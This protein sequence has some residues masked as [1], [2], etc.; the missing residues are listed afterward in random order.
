MSRPH[1]LDCGPCSQSSAL[2]Q[3]ERMPW[4]P[5]RD[6]EIPAPDQKAPQKHRAGRESRPRDLSP[7][8]TVLAGH[9]APWD[10]FSLVT[11]AP[12]G[13]GV[14]PESGIG[15]PDSPEKVPI[16]VKVRTE[17]PST[18]HHMENGNI[19]TLHSWAGL[20]T[21]PTT[22]EA[23]AG[24]GWVPDPDRRTVWIFRQQE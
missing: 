8:T 20:P 9:S 23:A 22:K 16:H 24:N 5:P 2:S 18:G 13:Q 14:T 7:G 12:Y 1:T 4:R 17:N 21:C 6:R 11:G 10:G 3:E 19:V 15:S